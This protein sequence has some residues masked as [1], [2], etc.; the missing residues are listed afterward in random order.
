VTNG[1]APCALF[2]CVDQHRGLTLGMPE[3]P[4]LN[5]GALLLRGLSLL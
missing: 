4:N 1:G 2:E 3:P 5:S